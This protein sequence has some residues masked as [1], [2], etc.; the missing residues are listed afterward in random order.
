MV[1]EIRSRRS[2][3]LP[4]FLVQWTLTAAFVVLPSLYRLLQLDNTRYEACGKKKHGSTEALFH[5][6]ATQLPWL[7]GLW[8]LVFQFYT[9]KLLLPLAETVLFYTTYSH[10]ALKVPFIYFIYSY[11]LTYKWVSAGSSSLLLFG[12]YKESGWVMVH[13]SVA[14]CFVMNLFSSRIWIAFSM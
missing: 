8:L 11:L 1:A 13:Y 10:S 14:L 7:W 5:N 3:I 12:R 6:A 2:L 4:A 9:C